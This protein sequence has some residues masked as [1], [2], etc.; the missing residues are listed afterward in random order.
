MMDLKINR[1]IIPITETI[2]DEKQEQSVELDYVLPDY[3]PDIFRIISCEIC[4]VIVSQSIGTDRIAYELRCDICVLYC[5][6]GSTLL[7]RVFQQLNFSRSV[8]LPRPV[9]SP[10]VRLTPKVTYSNCRAVSSRRL[11]VRGAVSIQM[12]IMGQRRQ[13]VIRDVFGMHIQLRKAPVEYIAQKRT[14]VK[15]MM[16][17]EEI[18]LGASKPPIHTLIRHDIR[19]EHQ[20][21]SIL[22]GKL[23]AKGEVSIRVLYAWKKASEENGM[24]QLRFTIPYSQIIDM[25]QIDESYQGSVEAQIIRC[26]FNPSGGK[27]GVM[28]TLQCELELRLNCTAVKTASAQLVTDA[29][30]TLYPCEQ[31]TVP[32]QIDMMPELVRTTFSCNASIP[33]GDTM[34]TCIYDLRCNVRNINMQLSEDT[35]RIRISGMLCCNLLAGDEEEN[36]MLL[37]KEEAFEAYAD[38]GAS[39]ENAV[40]RGQVTPADCTYHL[41]SDGTVSIQATLLL[42]G[43]LCP[44]S[45][46]IFLSDLTIDEENK[47]VRDGDYA[48]K[49]YYGV[50]HEDVWEI[51]K[52]CHTSVDAI[53]EENDLT[54]NQ[55]TASGMLFIPIVH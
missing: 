14:A 38:P 29:F 10:T 17:S 1:E 48:L 36:P 53:M 24:E 51:A 52:R 34:P 31:T 13:E 26:D 41:A 32:L 2:L 43:Q 46:H 54:E 27:N 42:T 50:E 11:E 7:H 55:L 39:V 9:D 3:D 35:N 12:H 49:L 47:L 8:E 45:R 19:L 25:E 37:E 20:E 6:S 4:P 28:N 22:A 33:P 44:A 23:I 21:Q 18:E 40:L 16:L 15:N 30:S 5:S